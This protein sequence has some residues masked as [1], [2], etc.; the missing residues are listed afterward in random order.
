MRRVTVLLLVF[1][2]IAPPGTPK[3]EEPA[4][5]ADLPAEVDALIFRNTS[6]NW[7]SINRGNR[8]SAQ[9]EASRRYLNCD[10]V[11]EDLATL[12]EQYRNN[13]RVLKALDGALLPADVDDII[14][15]RVGCDALTTSASKQPD[16]TSDSEAARRYLECDSVV[17]D[18]AALRHKY[19]GDP[20]ILEAL[21]TKWVR[22]IRRV[23]LKIAPQT[24]STAPSKEQLNGIDR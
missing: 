1:G 8:S 11:A 3:A 15:R 13:P 2:V 9:V 23:P 19:N 5:Q 6:C 4:S 16:R 21:D 10:V 24:D 7:S 22:V 17:K 18:E 14:Q 12:R 20:R